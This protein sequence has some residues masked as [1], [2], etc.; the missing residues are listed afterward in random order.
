[1]LENLNGVISGTLA[2]IQTVTGIVSEMDTVS[3]GITV[4]GR[5]DYPEYDGAYEITPLPGTDQILAT[6]GRVLTENVNVLEIPYYETTNESGGY[7]VSIG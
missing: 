5:G 4:G 6:A 3:G 7:T 1:M 2:T